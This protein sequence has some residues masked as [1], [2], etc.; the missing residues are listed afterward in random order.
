[1]RGKVA[2]GIRRY[3]SKT[4]VSQTQEERKNITRQIKR[5]YVSGKLDTSKGSNVQG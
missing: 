4:Y 2:R 3:V 5:D 1:M